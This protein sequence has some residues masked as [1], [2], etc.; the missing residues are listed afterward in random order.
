MV[1]GT[2]EREGV[3]YLG[4]QIYRS[5]EEMVNKNIVPLFNQIQDK[6]KYWSSYSLSWPGRIAAIKM[7]LSPKL[8][9]VLSTV[10]LIIL[11]SILNRLHGILNRFP[12]G[13]K[14]VRINSKILQQHLEEVELAVPNINKYYYAALVT[15]CHDWRDFLQRMLI[16]LWKRKILWRYYQNG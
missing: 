13:N 12:W 8:I 15:A 11:A 4:I 5:N 7:V 2:W 14:R 6:C 3:R 10:I 9:F 16:L 1:P